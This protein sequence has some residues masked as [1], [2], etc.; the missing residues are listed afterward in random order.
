MKLDL[1]EIEM[2]QTDLNAGELGKDGERVKD[3]NRLTKRNPV[4]ATTSGQSGTGRTV[5]ADVD[6]GLLFIG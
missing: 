3:W 6:M 2:H 4:Q 1:K 5:N